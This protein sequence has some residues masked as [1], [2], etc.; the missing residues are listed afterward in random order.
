MLK[1]EMAL[2]EPLRNPVSY[3]CHPDNT[4]HSL[5]GVICV[6]ESTLL[7]PGFWVCRVSHFHTLPF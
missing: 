5:L 7:Q 1:E 3:L 4:C 2:V 6:E